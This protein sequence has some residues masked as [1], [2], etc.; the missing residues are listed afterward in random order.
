MVVSKEMHLHLP[1]AK[2]QHHLFVRHFS[3]LNAHFSSKHLIKNVPLA[4]PTEFDMCTCGRGGFTFSCY[5]FRG[6]TKVKKSHQQKPKPYQIQTL[7][8]PRP[9]LCTCSD[10]LPRVLAGQWH[11]ELSPCYAMQNASHELAP[12]WGSFSPEIDVCNLR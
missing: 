5:L 8:S 10:S 3:P 2:T 11:S 4:V 7:P 6:I 9:N 12:V 1:L